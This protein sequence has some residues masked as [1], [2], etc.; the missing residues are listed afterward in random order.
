[1]K[2]RTFR[3]GVALLPVLLL[4]IL[5]ANSCAPFLRSV[6]GFSMGASYYV[7]YYAASD[8]SAE[9][10]AA[11]SDVDARYSVSFGPSCV[12]ML[13]QSGAGAAVSLDEEEYRAFSRVFALAESSDYAFDPA[14][15]PL[16]KLWGF[17]PPVTGT[18][19]PSSERISETLTHSSLSLFSLSSDHTVSKSDAA[20]MLD[21]GAA[22]KGYAAER[23]RDVLIAA[24]ASSALVYIGGT[25]A[26]VGEDCRIGV[27]PPRDSKESFA[28][29]FVLKSGEICATSGDYERYFEYDGVRYHHILDPKTGAPATS[30]VISA[31]V[32]SSDG[33][34]ADAYATAAVVLGSEK[35]LAL[36]ERSNVRAALITRDLKVITYNVDVT[37]KDAS[38]VAE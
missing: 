18:V 22:M 13:D 8:L 32:I 28:F 11:I 17:D 36:F 1:M 21:F 30:D 9:I 27:T 19:P 14:I 34:M 31:T 6:N 26:A 5:F 20:A 38:Y 16:V 10:R 7:D 24:N 29:S 23:V 3:R 4:T 35:A 37:I 33:M 2:G 15:F 25:I 12:S